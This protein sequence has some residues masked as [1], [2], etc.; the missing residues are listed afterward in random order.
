MSELFRSKD[1]EENMT[2]G[3]T[4]AESRWVLLMTMAIVGVGLWAFLRL[5]SRLAVQPQNA[6]LLAAVQ[7]RLSI[8]LVKEVALNRPDL[9]PV[10][11]SMQMI[12]PEAERAGQP[13]TLYKLE[14]VPAIEGSDIAAV[15]E[16]KDEFDAPRLILVLTPAGTSRFASFT[17]KHVGEQAAIV[18]SG[19]VVSAPII[20]SAIPGGKLQVT[21]LKAQDLLTATKK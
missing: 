15:E 10:D 3:M 6:D 14:K 4:K 12:L 7:K 11:A 8:H 17:G 21:G 5:E 18:D 19:V 2:T 1:H 20:Q 9:E 13:V 16:S